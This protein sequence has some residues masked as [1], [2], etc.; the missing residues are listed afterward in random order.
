MIF[1]TIGMQKPFPRFVALLREW[2]RAHPGTEVVLQGAEEDADQ[3]PNLTCHRQLSE[4]DFSALVERASVVVAHA[5][6]G[7]ILAAREAGVP[8]VLVPRRAAAGEHRNDHQADTIAALAGAPGLFVAE[9]D[10]EL[11]DAIDRAM[12]CHVTPPPQSAEL[13][14]LARYVAKFALGQ[15]PE[16]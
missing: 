5:G 9:D 14:R 8:V 7:T 4:R 15:Q 16:R 3:P 10:G 2:A 12:A 6:V 11:A 1:A 13:D